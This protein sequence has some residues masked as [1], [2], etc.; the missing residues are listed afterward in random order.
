MRILWLNHRDPKHPKAGGAEVHLREVGKRLVQWGCDVTLLSER[1]P[2]S[3]Q[4]E[5]IDGIKVVRMGGKF[6]IHL[7]APLEVTRLAK[8]I[9]VVIDDIAHGV[10]WWSTIVT[11]RPVVGIVHH[12]HQAIVSVELGFILGT[13]VKLAEKTTKFS[14]ERIITDSEASRKQMET[15]LGIRRSHVD[16]VYLGVDHDL[17]RPS[18]EKFEDPTVLWVGRIKRYKNVE[19][20]IAAFSI[21]KVSVPNL[22]LII[23]GDGDQKESLVRLARKLGLKDILFMSSGSREQKVRLFQKCWALCMTS[24]IE[25]WGLVIIEAAACA[26]PTIAYDSGASGEAII[27][28]KTGLLA[29]FGNVGQL[30][31]K[32]VLL[33]LNHRLRESLSSLARERS[34]IFDWDKT[35]RETLGI[36]E[37][38]CNG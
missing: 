7:R 22:K 1:F 27:D 32:I 24:T 35:A 8:Q 21:A 30:A 26:T 12:V 28:G 2:G 38:V 19:H 3:K 14:Y 11:R 33:A 4:T 6:G 37:E 25:G 23:Y 36:L 31:E 13:A 17:Y 5:I 10:P 15:L 34:L 29:R 9:D 20:I 18:V 16:V